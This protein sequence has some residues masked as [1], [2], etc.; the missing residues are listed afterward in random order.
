MKK[1]L[2][3]YLDVLKTRN[4]IV[5]TLIT[6]FYS[7]T[8][9]H[10]IYTLFLKSRGLNFWQIFMLETVISASIF[11]FEIP[12]GYIADKIGRKKTIIL[13]VICFAV[14]SYLHVIS[15][16]FLM[17]IILSAIFGLGIA[18]ISGADSALI[19]ESLIA[20]NKKE[21]SDYAFSLIGGAATA[22]LILSLPLG[23]FLAQYSLDLPVYVTCIPLTISV[24]AALFLEETYNKNEKANENREGF[25]ESLI[26]IL[27]EKPVLV[28]LQVLTSLSFSIILSMHYLN[29][30]LFISY[31]VKIK[32]FGIIMLAVNILSML[33]TLLSPRLKK[34]LGTTF[35]LFLRNFVP[36][37]FIIILS[38]TTSPY[39]GIS[40]F[41]GVLAVNSIGTPI[42]RSLLNENI[43]GN[44]RATVLSVISF[45]GSIVGMC[46]KPLIGYLV[47]LSLNTS[48][49]I[50]GISIIVVSFGFLIFTPSLL[51][52]KK[53]ERLSLKSSL[54]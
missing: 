42:F 8:F 47:D 54:E 3:N 11:V 14:S 6:F 25:K 43:S 2:K 35:I 33:M 32:Y 28:I 27:K 40:A 22:A 12:S 44:N 45:I 36:G 39:L 48:L 15:Y 24:I 30:P 18:S 50:L 16:N 31:G 5:L 34:K 1:E 49:L 52:N 10:T 21:Y 29:Q 46:T 37:I 38:K 41:M 53:N 51:N 23:G 13:S 26:F 9:H 17:F 7:L 20:D 19:Y 4:V